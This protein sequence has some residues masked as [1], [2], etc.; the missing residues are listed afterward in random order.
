MALRLLAAFTLAALLVGCGGK[1]AQPAFPD[2]HPVKGVVKRGGQ[3]VAGG[4]VRFT[5]D[6]DRPE[7]LVNSEVGPDGTF[8][9]STVRTTD[10]DGE[11]RLG[12]PAGKYR[13][14]YL[15]PAGDQ[16]AGGSTTP[17][18][19]P[20]AVTVPAPDNDVTIDLTKR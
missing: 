7:F 13:V 18:E 20:D 6:P 17:V 8:L 1:S 16:T 12:A 9:L 5:P 11:R 19:L 10:K 14:A 4:S 2:L 3:A 15:P